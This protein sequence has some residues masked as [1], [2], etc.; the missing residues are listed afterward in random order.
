MLDRVYSPSY[1]HMNVACG[2]H[3]DPSRWEFA[4]YPKLIRVLSHLATQKG[5]DERVALE[6]SLEF[7]NMA[8]TLAKPVRAHSLRDAREDVENMD[9]D[10]IDDSVNTV[11][12]DKLKFELKGECLNYNT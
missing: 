3:E 7:N 10:N 2:L 12:N 1:A 11:I 8:D 9:A 6:N 5:E 4:E